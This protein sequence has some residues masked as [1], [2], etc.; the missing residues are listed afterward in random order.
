MNQPILK[1]STSIVL[2]HGYRAR[3]VLSQDDINGLIS[4]AY[5]SVLS[6]YKDFLSEHQLKHFTGPEVLLSHSRL[7]PIVAGRYIVA[8]YL[9]VVIGWTQER[10]AEIFG[11]NRSFVSCA[12]N[13]IN[14][15]IC[16]RDELLQNAWARMEVTM[17][18]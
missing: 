4:A 15:A 17:K 16:G 6:A 8:Y 9:N 14:N 12:S 11:L 10:I 7:R 2:P 5:N 1:G 18:T 13:V 3:N